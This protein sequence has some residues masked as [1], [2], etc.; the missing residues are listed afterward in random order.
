MWT[1]DS[2]IIGAGVRRVTVAHDRRP[3]SY[4]D[5]LAGW[6]EDEDFRAFFIRLLSEVPFAA[7]LW[8]TPPITRATVARDF[9]CV[10]A[11]SPAL[12]RFAPDPQAFARHF[13]AAGPSEGVVAFPNL[14]GDAYLVAPTPRAEP[15]AY[16]HLAAFARRAPA[17]QQD[18][19]WRTVGAETAARLS[20]RPLWL[21]SC[22][23]GVAWLHARLDS[24]PKY[25]THQPY[26]TAAREGGA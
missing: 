18:A 4:A 2:E 3:L 23:L 9:E 19:F 10:F 25:Y 22:G 24:W 7:Y 17:D 21:S 14:G 1:I 5:A 16:P 8:E 26:R 15:G 20:D 11:E 6:Q 12:A 13:D